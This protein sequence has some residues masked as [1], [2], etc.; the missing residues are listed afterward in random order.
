MTFPIANNDPYHIFFPRSRSDHAMLARM[1]RDDPV[2]S[3]T[4]PNWGTR[5][6]F[7]TRYEDCNSF[8]RD[9]RFG[10]DL[11]N[12]LP[13]QI[14]EHWPAPPLSEQMFE[15]HLLGVD[16]PD[17]TRMRG[18]VHKAFTPRVI[19]RLQDRVQE[20]ADQLLDAVQDAGEMDL[21]E[22][23]AFP[24]PITMISEMLG[25]PTADRN[26][27]RHWIRQLFFGVADE[28]S[29][30]AAGMEF[31]QYMRERIDKRR[32]EPQEDILSG[33]VHASEEGDMLNAQELMSM[34]FLLLTAGYET[35][36][37]L[38]GTGTYTLLANP[39]QLEL[40]CREMEANQE[41]VKRAVEEIVRYAG[42]ATGVFMRWAW[43][44][45]QIGTK[46]IQQGDSVTALLHA[47]NRDPEVFEDPDRFDITRSP[48][49]H[50]GYGAGVHYCLGAPLAR[51]EGAVAIPTL[52]RRLP[53]LE[54]AIEPDDVVWN[55]TGLYGLRELPVRF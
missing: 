48:N 39:D 38:I 8:L 28:E 9:P 6:W 23:Y 2:Y 26:R 16:P 35:T 27:F 45:V 13:E 34:I 31:V 29:R 19:Q 15:R 3:T 18:L 40:L 54:L 49:N 7:L 44:D 11:H 42:P 32:A 52:L 4:V 55:S 25:V 37:H 22:Q 50:L 33:M 10:R 14:L 1:R 47:A 46:T 41:L 21:I 12:K 36:V 5:H 24:I 20:V 53:N 30:M 43:E 17:H 51:M